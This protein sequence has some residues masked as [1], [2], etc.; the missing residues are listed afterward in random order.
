MNKC[1]KVISRKVKR[2]QLFFEG[3]KALVKR[4]EIVETIAVDKDSSEGNVSDI[5]KQQRDKIEYMQFYLNEI[6]KSDIAEKRNSGI[7]GV[8]VKEDGKYYYAEIE[9]S[10]NLNRGMEVIHMCA[11]GNNICRRMNGLSDAEGGCEKVRNRSTGIENF[12][13]IRSGYESFNTIQDSLIVK[14]CVNFTEP[15]PRKQYTPEE[16]FKLKNSFRQMCLDSGFELNS[17]DV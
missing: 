2:Y 1:W 10:I 9:K 4:S 16:K 14:E 6:S 15:A 7:P 17:E 5:T 8:I 13:C 11:S 3:N 12:D